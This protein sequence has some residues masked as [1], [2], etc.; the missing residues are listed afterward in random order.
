VPE[1]AGDSGR[2]LNMAPDLGVALGGW[3]WGAQFCDLNN[4]GFQDLF[5]TNGFISANPKRSYWY[6]FSEITS[7]NSAIISD[8]KNW[9]DL[10]D[11]SLSG[12]QKKNVWIN[13]GAGKFVNVASLVGV[14]ETYDGRAVAV[15]DFWNRGAQDIVVSHQ[16]GPLLLYRNEL[17]PGRH[18]IQFELEGRRGH[19]SALGA[20]VKV[21]WA[22]QTQV[23]IVAS[24][25]GFCAQNQ[26]RLH[27][28]LGGAT[29]VDEVVIRWPSGQVQKLKSPAVDRL[30]RIVE[31][32]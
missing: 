29:S 12:Y 24:A 3:S 18:W 16:K 30:H 4:D 11:M 5:C 26:R 21:S 32:E 25:S 7:A 6:A 9:P 2:F 19:R 17:D 1:K 10:E 20:M 22:G 14:S 8:A 15:A 31:P 23:Q 13:D 28:G 27:Y